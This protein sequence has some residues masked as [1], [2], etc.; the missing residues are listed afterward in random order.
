MLNVI[1]LVPDPR[2][3]IKFLVLQKNPSY[4]DEQRLIIDLSLTLRTPLERVIPTP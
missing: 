4:S 2:A 1:Q 3:A